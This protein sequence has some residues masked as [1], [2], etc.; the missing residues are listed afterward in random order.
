M[1][2]P[3]NCRH[4]YVHCCNCGKRSI[5]GYDQQEHLVTTLDFK[6][7]TAG[8]VTC[9][10]CSARMDFRGW[11]LNEMLYDYEKELEARFRKQLP[12][13]K[14]KYEQK[15]RALYGD[16]FDGIKPIDATCLDVNNGIPVLEFVRP[17]IL[18]T[19]E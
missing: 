18:P 9:C 14:K 8:I 16:R 7:Y 19:N 17:E 2:Y 15:M 4:I 10:H 6:S 3:Q 1:K 12:N 13:R 11:E 5:V